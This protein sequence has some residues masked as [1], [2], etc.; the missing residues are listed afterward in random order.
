MSGIHLEPLSKPVDD[1]REVRLTIDFTHDCGAGLIELDQH[2][3][4]VRHAVRGPCRVLNGPR[5]NFGTADDE[6]NRLIGSY[7]SARSGLEVPSA[8]GISN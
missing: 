6:I 4:L 2:S 7:P 1:F 3:G 8:R 5:S